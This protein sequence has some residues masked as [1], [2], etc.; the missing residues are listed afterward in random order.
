M[1]SEMCIR[2]RSQG[3]PRDAH[4]RDG[5][6][7]QRSAFGMAREVR[8]VAAVFFR[9][10]LGGWGTS[11]GGFRFGCCVCF[12]VF[13]QEGKEDSGEVFFS[14]FFFFVKMTL[15]LFQVFFTGKGGCGGAGGLYFR[16]DW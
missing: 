5:G 2:D 1:G 6:P 13:S 10:G 14:S 3:A 11:C 9:A 7:F 4:E 12:V 15:L 16:C 8:S